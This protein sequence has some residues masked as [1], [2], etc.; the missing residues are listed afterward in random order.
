[1]PLFPVAHAHTPAQ[2]L[3]QFGHR[4]VVQLGSS[5]EVIAGDI[6]K[7]ETLLP[8]VQGLRV[9]V[10]MTHYQGVLNTLAAARSASFRGRFVYLN[11]G[12]TN[13]SLAG[14]L[15]NL[16]K[17]NTLI[18]RRHVEDE[19]RASGLDYTI[20]R[21]GFLLNHPGGQRAV[22]V[23]QTALPLAP[24][25]RIA[26]ADAAEAFVEAMQHPQASRTTIRHRM[27]QRQ[28]RRLGYAI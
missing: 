26:R 3:I 1:M 19:I 9:K 7:P 10:L 20:I 27:G 6:T 22:E 24:G 21:V 8:A 13:P 25:N 28:P 5:I 12:V 16:L 15:L 4:T 23:S 2:P 11:S 17:R 18:W 14:S